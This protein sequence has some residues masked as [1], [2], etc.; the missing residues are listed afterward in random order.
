MR[1]SHAAGR[2][3]PDRATTDPAG[4][5]AMLCVHAAIPTLLAVREPEPF[6]ADA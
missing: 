4:Q 3:S 5:M 2:A 1:F 6:G